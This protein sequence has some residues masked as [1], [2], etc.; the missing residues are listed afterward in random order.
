M[1][2]LERELAW[3]PRRAPKIPMVS[4]ST[5]RLVETLDGPY[6][7]AQMRGTVLF[8]PAVETLLEAG[9][10]LFVEVGPHPVSSASIDEVADG[11]DVAVVPAMRRGR[12]ERETLL[13]ALGSLHGHGQSVDWSAFYDVPGRVASRCHYRGANGTGFRGKNERP[14]QTAFS[15][16]RPVGR[17]QRASTSS[18]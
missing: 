17:N 4:T 14:P 16:A 3:L 5:G 9:H 10:E 15:E 2:E 8:A 13:S 18:S 12:D 6:W 1:A 7:G 11:R